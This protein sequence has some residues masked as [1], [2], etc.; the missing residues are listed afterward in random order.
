MDFVTL[1][2]RL[3]AVAILVG[4]LLVFEI[5]AAFFSHSVA[6]LSDVAHVGTDFLSAL[7]TLFAERIAHRPSTKMMSYGF[8]RGTVVAAFVNGFSLILLSIIILGQTVMR[9]IYPEP[10]HPGWMIGAALVALFVDGIIIWMLMRGEQNLNIKSAFVHFAGDAFVSLGVIL[11]AVLVSVTHKPWFDPIITFI[12]IVVMVYTS[13]RIVKESLLILMEGTP[14][15]INLEMLHEQIS[16]L[17]GILAIHDIHV[18]A[19][20]DR[21]IAA[22][23]HVVIGPKVVISETDRLIKEIEEILKLRFGIVHS[24]IQLE[25]QVDPDH[26]GFPHSNKYQFY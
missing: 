14:N 19:V 16:R 18:W 24:A 23:L 1:V 7:L 15:T 9:L 26:H 25:S 20:S 8:A 2:R 5:I 6:L 10:V 22:S 17:P 3:S 12:L 11:A 21:D 4:S 13:W